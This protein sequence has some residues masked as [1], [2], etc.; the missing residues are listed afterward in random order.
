[1]IEAKVVLSEENITLAV[2]LHYSYKQKQ[3]KYVPIFGVLLILTAIPV[4]TSYGFSSLMLPI[5]I[6]GLLLIGLQF[7]MKELTKRNFKSIPTFNEEIRYQFDEAKLSATSA[8]T[9]FSHTWESMSEAIVRT[10]GILVYPQK[11][12]FLWLPKSTFSSEEEFHQV[13][14]YV[15][16]GVPN[17]KDV[18]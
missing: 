8:H 12:A 7:I 2:N 17:Y 14:E 1:M 6:W 3:L 15:Q 11:N 4:A 13:V 5:L 16:N 18:K 9:E 10:D